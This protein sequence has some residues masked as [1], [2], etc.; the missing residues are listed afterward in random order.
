MWN[1][2]LLLVLHVSFL[3]GQVGGCS[4]TL[5]VVDYRGRPAPYRLAAFR[6]G[7]GSDFVTEFVN[8]KGRVPCT[9]VPYT[10]R[11]V[12]SG[13]D[14]PSDT[15]EGKAYAGDP[16]SALTVLTDPN[17][18]F[19]GNQ[20]YSIS[21]VL[22]VGYVWN[23]HVA[24]APGVRLWVHIQSA[25]GSS[26]IEAEVDLNG[27]FKIYRGFVQG[28]HLLT[29]MN[30]EGH[31]VYSTTLDITA[32]APREDLGIKISPKPPAVIVVR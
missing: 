26:H 5:R 28:P 30:D 19:I 14:S 27:D 15:I 3:Y 22:P 21:R 29:I 9:V 6:N 25:V 11:F 13:V 10:F 20:A 23:G 7:V 24:P 12:R 17:T 1:L 2:V 18:L 4:V 8:M 32:F 31:I 16:E